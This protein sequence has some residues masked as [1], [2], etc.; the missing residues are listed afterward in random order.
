MMIAN[1]HSH[2]VRCG[3]AQGTEREY[4]EA[5]VEAGLKILGFSDHSPY[6]LAEGYISGMRMRLEETEG[7]VRVLEDLRDEYRDE[8][9]LHIGLEAEY[10]PERFGEYLD[11]IKDYPIEYLILGQHMLD[12]DRPGAEWCGAPTADRRVL[13]RYVDQVLEGLG[14]GKF[15]YLAHP[16]LINYSGDNEFYRLEMRRLIRG[17]KALDVPIELNFLGLM[18][19]RSYP[20]PVFW[21]MAGEEGAAVIYGSD[22]HRPGNVFVPWVYEKAERWRE[23]YGLRVI[24]ELD[25][26]GAH[27]N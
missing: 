3:H 24:P 10:M 27:P 22:A 7:Y 4:V 19:Q 23:K 26:S 11:F 2:T 12:E 21:Q 16:D 5:G 9:E 25:L 20:N 1:Y 8:I 14:T 15:L 13:T 17:A 6:P 18:E